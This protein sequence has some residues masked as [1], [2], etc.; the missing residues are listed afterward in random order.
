MM[1]KSELLIALE[2]IEKDKKIKKEDILTV[3]K[4]ALISAYKKHVGK[5]VNVEAKVD[6][7]T[8]E[9]TANVI[10]IIVKKVK[11]PLLEICIQDAK[12]I[13]QNTKIGDE[14]KIPL[15]TQDFSRIAAQTAKQ[16]IIQKIRESERDS[17]FEEMKKKIG[18][19]INGVIYH[20]TNKNLVVDLGK[21]EA[22]IPV[23]EQVFKE[24]FNIGQHIKTI[25]MK[26]ERN[27]KGSGI[28]LS[29]AS[30]E[31][32]KKLFENEVPEIHE[33]IVEII[34][35]VRD[36]GIRTKIAVLSH[37]PK[38]D[39]VGACVG[40]KGVRIKPIIDELRGERIDIISYYTDPA[41]YIAGALSP[42]KVISVVIVSE[43]KK[44]AELLVANDMLSLAIGKNGHNV[45]LAA[46]LTG[47]HIDVK[48]EEQKKRESEVKIEKQ[49]EI[50]EKLDGLSKKTIE[51]LVKSGFTDIEKLTLLT[52]SDLTTL[53]GVGPKKAEKIIEEAKR[54]FRK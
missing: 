36:P 32:V 2:Q 15:N 18:Q 22:I 12:R 39:P 48:S 1:E 6:S 30:I 14:I 10:K 26:V 23:S 47:W 49:T 42:A 53:P 3:I 8:G 19:L 16:V 46:K 34:N 7:I 29:R 21:T 44:K 25:I 13:E 51:I 4:N 45:R 37:N 20:T 40:I 27:V 38:V 54:V 28:I 43:D 5:D 35:V 41:K 9:M 50:L 11:N 17:I 24:K 52:I 33:E 31:F